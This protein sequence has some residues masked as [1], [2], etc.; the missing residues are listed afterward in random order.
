M[1]DTMEAPAAGTHR[2]DIDGLRAV[3]VLAVLVFHAAPAAAPGGFVGV[4]VFFVVSGFLIT[5]LIVQRRQAGTFTLSDFYA[6]RVRRLL[7]ALLLVLAA[8]VL[9]GA[10]GLTGDELRALGRM[11]VAS[12]CFVPNVVLWHDAGYFA[13]SAIR[14]PLLHLWSLGVEEQFYLLWPIV[15]TTL[16][17]RRA[18]RVGAAVAIA[19]LSFSIGLLR[20]DA[21]PNEVFYLPHGRLW[22]PMLGALLA[23]SGPGALGRPGIRE[24]V[25]AVG[26]AAIAGAIFGLD[27]ATPFPGP[28]AF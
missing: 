17:S 15:L 9:V 25:S 13:P 19:A 7:P 18:T 10:I 22:E 2:R 1:M 23:L 27:Q 8:C 11:I 3:A 24:A 6:R 16:G 26:L 4:D 5:G 28:W 20:M 12:A 21:H 14:Q